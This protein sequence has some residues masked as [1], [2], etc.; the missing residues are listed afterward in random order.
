MNSMQKKFD[1]QTRKLSYFRRV[2]EKNTTYNK[3]VFGYKPYQIPKA[4]YLREINI[5]KQL[6]GGQ[7]Q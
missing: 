5:I 7:V 4:Q 2:S 1:V 6:E 3:R